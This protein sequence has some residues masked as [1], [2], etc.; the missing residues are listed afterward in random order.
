MLKRLWGTVR[1]HRARRRVTALCAR[2]MKIGREV[3]LMDDVSFDATYPWLIEI[4]DGC[5]VSSQVRIMCHDAQA[6]W[7]LGITRLGRVRILRGSFI[8][9]RAM[10]LPGVTIG[11]NAVV[12]AGSV[13]TRDVGEGAMVGGNPAKVYGR[14][15]EYLA[16]QAA[17]ADDAMLFPRRH[18]VTAEGRAAI[19]DA[20]AG[21][22]T[23]FLQG[24]QRRSKYRYGATDAEIERRSALAA[25]R[26]R[27]LRRGDPLLPTDL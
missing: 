1:S 6:F 20:L 12:A 22:Q 9:E 18:P 16:R 17:A 8:G 24:P 5:R 21:G 14:L 23:V 25:E 3:V 4:E 7:H 19:L 15:D 27:R 26:L 11:P 2:G 13:V 10:I